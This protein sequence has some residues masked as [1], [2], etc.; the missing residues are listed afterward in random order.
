MRSTKLLIALMVIVVSMSVGAFSGK[1]YAQNVA[2]DSSEQ[3]VLS[4]GENSASEYQNESTIE[5]IFAYPDWVLAGEEPPEG[6]EIVDGE[7]LY[8]GNVVEFMEPRGAV[9]NS[10]YYITNK[11]YGKYIYNETTNLQMK[12]GLIADI[13][14]EIKWVVTGGDK[15]YTI[16]S[17]SNGN[18]LLGVPEDTTSNVVR[19]EEIVV[20]SYPDRFYWEITIASGGGCILKNIYNGK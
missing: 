2:E 4:Q 11:Q 10:V 19:A 12:S 16:R 20:P 6:Y 9:S 17:F 15:G 7:V 3:A 1:G 14:T 13:G 8:D 5:N 18:A